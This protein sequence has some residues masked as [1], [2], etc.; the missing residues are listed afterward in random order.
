[1]EVP[2]SI[3][4]LVPTSRINRRFW[5][6]GAEL[7]TGVYAPYPVTVRNARLANEPIA[8]DTFGFCLGRHGT[9][10]ADFADAA[11][12][13]QIYRSEVAEYVRRTTGAD[14]VV[15]LGGMMRS[16][17]AT[18]PGC[19]PPAAEAHVDFTERT[20]RKLANRLYAQARPQGA[21]YDRFIAF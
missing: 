12:V 4:Y 17:G 3:H 15:P 5:A 18:G 10:V 21:G 14:F 11:N 2:T 1:C 6:P 9:A 19:Q 7:N 13:A 20:A 16:S 8:L